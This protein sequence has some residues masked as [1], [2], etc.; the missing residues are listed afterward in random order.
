MYLI[1]KK[2]IV[3]I[4]LLKLRKSPG[5]SKRGL[6]N[7]QPPNSL[8]IILDS[9]VLPNPEDHVINMI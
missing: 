9:V 3:F 5:L 1:N 7:F 4:N 6:S 2:N 8:A